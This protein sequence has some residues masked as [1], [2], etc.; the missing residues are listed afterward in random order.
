M[1][2]AVSVSWLVTEAEQARAVYKYV[3][4]SI[5]YMNIYI[6]LESAMT[7]HAVLEAEKWMAIS[8]SRLVTE[9]EQARAVYVYSCIYIY[10]CVFNHMYIYI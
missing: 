6:C 4:I 5:N 8:V 1:W 7:A 9:T 3:C 10:M 2:R